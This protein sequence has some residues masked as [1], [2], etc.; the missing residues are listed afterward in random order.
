VSADGADPRR[1]RTSTREGDDI[2][3]A[4]TRRE[5]LRRRLRGT[6]GRGRKLRGLVVLLA[7]YRSRVALM[8]IALV[9]GTAASL[10]PAPLAKTAIDSGILKGDRSTLD[11]VV[12]AF[13]VSALV[14]WGASYAQTYLVG[15]VGQRALADLRLQIF[16][17]L[18]EMPVGF[19]E[20]RPAGVLISRMTNDVEA[21]DSLVTD[22]VVTLFQ[23]SLTLV[24]SVVILLFL[25]ARLALLTFLIFP[26]MAIASLAF[27]I[28]SADA[29]RRT[30]ETISA[31]TAYL[32]ETLS[33]IRVVRAFAQEPRHR[34]Q[35][36][37]LN[38]T[39]REANMVTVNLNAAYFPGVEFVSAVAT[40][41][42][43]IVGGRQAINGD[44]EIGVLVGFI[45]ALNGF[46]DPIGQLSQVYTTYQSG[47]A[48]LD[49]I[50]ELLDEQPQLTDKPGAIELPRIRG[51]IEF[52]D[53]SFRYR[54]DAD[55]ARPKLALDGVSLAIPPG[56]TV[57]LVGATGAGKSTFAKLVA[58]FYDPTDGRVLVDGHDL[59]DVAARSLRS[60]MGIVPQEAFL[61][62]GTIGDN[63]AF[64]RPGASDAEIEAAARAVGAWDFIAALPEGAATEVGERGVQLSAGQRQLVAFARAL[65]ADPRI[66]VLDEAT[67]NVDL[68]TEGRIEAGLRRLLAGRTAIVIAHR[69]STIR[70]AGRIVVLDQ[71]RIVEQGTHEELIAAGGPYA[72]LYRD[73]AAQAAA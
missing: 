64:G 30:R 16:R 19:Y 63:I 33:G 66:L 49:K 52:D 61:F 35:F 53:V 71:G 8:A 38:E 70:Q 15:W 27:R 69:L 42:I 14:V 54:T 21:L 4:A 73:W 62:S 3:R 6:R 32:Q 40:V 68:H 59:R 39:N 18:Q 17:H 45:A 28:A 44:V 10:A 2:A 50:F 29:Y 34:A 46:F 48:A 36:G 11:L 51:E 47:M 13:I 56:Q 7:P 41:G 37:R 72:A 25:D 43:L 20:R 23:A 12:V 26:V 5:D 65:I 22:T 60:Q 31:I 1:G 57:A 67:S 55:P 24:G 58:R 9:A